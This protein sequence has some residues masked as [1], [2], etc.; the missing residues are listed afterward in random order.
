MVNRELE[1]RRDFENLSSVAEAVQAMHNFLQIQ[2]ALQ[3]ASLCF[4]K[5]KFKT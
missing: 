3:E 1:E 5:N 4:S 2:G